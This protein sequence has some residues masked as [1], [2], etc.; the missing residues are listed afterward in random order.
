M[1]SKAEIAEIEM[2][3][4]R[5]PDSSRN[6]SIENRWYNLSMGGVCLDNGGLVDRA[7]EFDGRKCA[8]KVD[9]TAGDVN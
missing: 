7:N 6:E 5:R 4:T 9:S 3:R 2:M 8:S 1:G